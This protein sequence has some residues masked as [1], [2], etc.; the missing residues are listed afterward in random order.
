MFLLFIQ[1]ER[2]RERKRERT[3]WTCMVALESRLTLTR[4]PTID[5]FPFY[6]IILVF[7]YSQKKIGTNEESERYRAS[8]YSKIE[9]EN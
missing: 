5:Y 9:L 8:L 1:R 6:F 2:E 4:Q 3:N 7:L